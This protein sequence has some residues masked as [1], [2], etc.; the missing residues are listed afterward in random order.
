MRARHYTFT[1]ESV[2]NQCLRLRSAKTLSPS[3]EKE[4]SCQPTARKATI[5]LNAG[6]IARDSFTSSLSSGEAFSLPCSR[7]MRSWPAAVECE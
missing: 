7:F 1:S 5:R 6:R 2:S 3:L 4:W